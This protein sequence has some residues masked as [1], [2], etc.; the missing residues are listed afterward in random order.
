MARRSLPGALTGT[1]LVLAA[2][3]LG[4]SAIHGTPDAVEI[5]G[6]A[7]AGSAVAAIAHM[8][9]RQPWLLLAL[10][11]IGDRL[12]A[13]PVAFDHKWKLPIAFGGYL[14]WLAAGWTPRAVLSA[15][16]PGL[17]AISVPLTPLD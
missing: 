15:P 1:L 6:L 13:Q 4:A 10:V 8:Q 12:A 3:V 14:L 5:V 9:L 16:A 2:G 7:L 17:P 11:V